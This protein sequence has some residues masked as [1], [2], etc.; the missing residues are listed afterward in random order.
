MNFSAIEDAF[1]PSPDKKCTAAD[2]G[3]VASAFPLATQAGV[4]MLR[5]GGNAVDA[6]CSAALALGVCEP[7]ASGLGGESKAIVCMNNATVAVDGSSR[8]PARI[9]IN[10]VSD[11]ELHVGYR[12]TSVPSTVAVLGYLHQ[13]YGSLT[14][15]EV[16]EPSIR[17]AREGYRITPLQHALQAR[18]L[19]L[20]LQVPSLSGA[21]YF[22]KDGKQ[23]YGVEELFIQPDL[24]SLLEDLAD[25]VP[26]FSTQKRW[27]SGSKRI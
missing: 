20:F 24:A 27:R 3:I 2:G 25:L 15:H 23:P 4:A 16:V 17:I 8:V 9:D 13:R 7:Q 22:L 1:L 19:P 11:Q 26:N 12:G 10:A 18:E 6:A 14:W 21:R 5:R